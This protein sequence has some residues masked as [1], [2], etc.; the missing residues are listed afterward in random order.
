M[1]LRATPK[2]LCADF[3]AH[4]APDSTLKKVGAKSA[5]TKDPPVR[6]VSFRAGDA[7]VGPVL[8][9]GSGGPEAETWEVHCEAE[10]R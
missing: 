6:E 3:R 4:R 5:P 2:V 8:I 1:F 9:R 7:P 10:G